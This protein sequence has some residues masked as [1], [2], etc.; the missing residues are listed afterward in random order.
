M[1]CPNCGVDPT[2]GQLNASAHGG[3]D[4]RD[5]PAALFYSVAWGDAW[6]FTMVELSGGRSLRLA[7]YLFLFTAVQGGCAFMVTWCTTW[8]PQV[9][10][11]VMTFALGLVVPGWIW[12]LTIETIRATVGKKDS[13][14]K[15]HFDIFQNMALGLKQIFWTIAFCWFPGAIVME[16]LAMIHMAMPVTQQGWINFAML[17]PFFAPILCPPCTSGS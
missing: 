6:K 4:A 15:V 1:E 10:F 14:R 11:G 3:R 7:L 13:I 12:C 5:D 9:F 16:P 17:T 8:P 2:T